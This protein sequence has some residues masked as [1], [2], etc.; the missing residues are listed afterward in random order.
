MEF[1]IRSK[2]KTLCRLKDTAAKEIALGIDIDAELAHV[3]FSGTLEV[4]R[5][6]CLPKYIGTCIAHA[7]DELHLFWQPRVQARRAHLGQVDAHGPGQVHHNIC[8]L[9]N[10]TYI[11]WI[12]SVSIR[13]FWICSSLKSIYDVRCGWSGLLLSHG[14]SLE[15]FS[16]AAET[17]QW[18]GPNAR[19]SKEHK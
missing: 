11:Y 19:Q 8:P 15:V 16:C 3:A 10:R 13:V 6:P 18:Q 2:G 5:E 7:A 1:I 17:H 4:C 9:S 12:A 14:T